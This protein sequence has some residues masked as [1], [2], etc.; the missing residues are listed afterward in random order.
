VGLAIVKSPDPTIVCVESEFL[1]KPEANNRKLA[2]EF[3]VRFDNRK[4][5][6]GV[7]VEVGNNDQASEQ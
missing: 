5:P 6:L 1:G 7:F 3:H 4:S 2:Q